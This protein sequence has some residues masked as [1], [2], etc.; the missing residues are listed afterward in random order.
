M[1][2][3]KD[4]LQYLEAFKD[5]H[6]YSLVELGFEYT[7]YMIVDHE[8]DKN[9]QKAVNLASNKL[10]EYFEV[11]SQLGCNCFL[12]TSLVSFAFMRARIPHE[13]T[14]G[15]VEWKSGGLYVSATR[16]SLVKDIE[17][18]FNP[19]IVEGVP[20]L[21][22]GRAHAWITLPNGEVVDPTIISACDV[23]LK[24]TGSSRLGFDQWIYRADNS[25]PRIARHIPM[26]TG[27][28]YHLRSVTGVRHDLRI[29]EEFFPWYGYWAKEYLSFMA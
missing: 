7:P 19:V 9:L 16:E 14:I 23:E 29:R 10:G 3:S 21:D 22:G 11:G 12:A 18:G 27:L 17:V 25:D 1:T 20:V 26:L 28:S 6:S 24:F 5:S 2:I 8:W 4:R 15:N 13:I